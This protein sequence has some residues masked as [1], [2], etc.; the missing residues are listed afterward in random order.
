MSISSIAFFF[1]G[2][3]R[4]SRGGVLKMDA[5]M[6][7]FDAEQRA[8]FQR[9]GWVVARS[10]APPEN[11][12]RAIDA[13]C[14][15]H[16]IAISDP[17]TWY[18]VPVDAWDVV[19][20]HQA[21]AFWD[22]RSL[23]LVHAAFAELHGTERLWVSMDRGGFKP[24][25][26]GHP[27]YDRTTDIH[28]D[29]KPRERIEDPVP[30]FQGMLFLTDTTAECGPFECVPSLYREAREWLAARPDATEPDA[31]GREIVKVT[32]RAGDLVIW[33]A[34][35]PHRGGRNDGALPRV[36]QYISMQPAGS[37]EK[38]AERVALW[39]ENRVPPHWRDWPPTVIDPEPSPRA[40]LD[41]LGRKLLGLDE[42]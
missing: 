39:R 21:Q 19:P 42:W 33:N 24:P 13:I 27:S 4:N 12:R 25:A 3:L 17:S 32:G 7:I 1:Q 34:L 5:A 11:V 22:N 2:T 37:R 38:A 30:F 40:A 20:V 41:A 26:S 10:V 9:E 15:F 36:T 29:A 6:P 18:R 14:G 23:P 8:H 16:G 31:T 28:W 35:L